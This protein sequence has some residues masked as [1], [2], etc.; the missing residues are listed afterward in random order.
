MSN[1]IME[2]MEIKSRHVNK[3][4]RSQLVTLHDSINIAEDCISLLQN[5]FIYNASKM[6]GECN[7]KIKV[8]KKEVARV[9]KDIQE[10]DHDNPELII[11]FSIPDHILNIGQSIEKLSDLIDRKISENLLFSD[12]AV[13][14]T[15]FLL[16]R[17]I[18]ILVPTAD[19]ILARNT[20]LSMYIEES[21]VGVGNT[22]MEYATLHEERLIK[23]ICMPS[24]SS[25]YISMLGII[26]NIAWQSKEIAVKLERK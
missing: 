16:Q 9:T 25:L 1:K 14:E 22:A 13:Q 6:L 8:I 26:K 18:E 2:H 3:D 12:K 15:V 4:L 5:A 24:A 17:L 11:F 20:F 7:L 10:N 19:I 23:G 21:Q